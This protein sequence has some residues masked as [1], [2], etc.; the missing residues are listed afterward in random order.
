MKSLTESCLKVIIKNNI[1]VSLGLIDIQVQLKDYELNTIK[2]LKIASSQ[3]KIN[4]SKIITDNMFGIFN[5]HDRPEEL[6]TIYHYKY[7]VY[8]CLIYLVN[9]IPDQNVIYCSRIDPYAEYY[10]HSRLIAGEN[11]NNDTLF[12]YMKFDTNNVSDMTKRKKLRGYH[13]HKMKKY[14]IEN[15]DPYDVNKITN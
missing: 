9:L 5:P 3:I 11:P 1:Q 12:T 7:C 8:N 2:E 13:M 4:S 10:L 14:P 6:Y 15:I